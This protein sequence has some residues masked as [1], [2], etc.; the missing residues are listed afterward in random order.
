MLEERGGLVIYK[1]F[2]LPHL[3]QSVTLY[4][5]DNTDFWPIISTLHHSEYLTHYQRFIYGIPSE[6]Q[7]T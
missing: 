1:P 2:L 6:D 3:M 7:T 4:E 5:N